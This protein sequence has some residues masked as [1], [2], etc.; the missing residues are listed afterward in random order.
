MQY[1]QYELI[2]STQNQAKRL[3]DSD[4]IQGAAIV[5]A[6]GQSAGRGQYGKSWASPLGAGL[7]AT[8]VTAR[9]SK[10]GV[11][12]F[13]EFVQTYTKT[14]AEQLLEVLND[15]YKADYYI[16][17]VNDI[18]YDGCKLAGI[19]VE[20]YKEHLIIGIGLNLKNQ[21]RQIREA[22][23]EKPKA[24]PISLEEIVPRVCFLKFDRDEFLKTIFLLLTEA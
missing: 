18:Y 17:P 12:R 8:I 16:K 15:F 10:L 22:L 4:Q 1:F 24:S 5:I 14:V 2:D 3:I 9:S 23:I 21:I 20:I 6:D 13:D 19:L 11:G 7:Y